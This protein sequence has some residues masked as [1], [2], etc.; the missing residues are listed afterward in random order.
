MIAFA[1]P[2]SCRSST[3]SNTAIHGRYDHYTDILCM[4]L[5]ALV[6]AS[7]LTLDRAQQVVVEWVQRQT[8]VQQ[9][10]FLRCLIAVGNSYKGR[11]V[12]PR[13]AQLLTGISTN[14]A[15][16][17]LPL[18]KIPEE[19]SPTE[20]EIDHSNNNNIDHTNNTVINSTGNNISV[21]DISIINSIENI[22]PECEQLVPT[23]TPTSNSKQD[24]ILQLLE[25]EFGY[26]DGGRCRPS[27]ESADGRKLH[28]ALQLLSA[29]LYSSDVHFIMELIQNADDNHYDTAVVI[30]TL[31]MQLFPHAIVVFNNEIGF[32][33][34]NITAVCNVNGSTKANKTGYIGQKGIG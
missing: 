5:N 7:K 3:G 11:Q 28:K 27:Q 31:H 13:L 2:V 1:L 22:T 34:E 33:K 8:G 10:K 23:H 6:Y 16:Y 12:L 32:S 4:C 15:C 29:S 18:Q 24:V 30:P 17:L 26:T 20:H 21:N 9:R 25:Q 14:S 19:S